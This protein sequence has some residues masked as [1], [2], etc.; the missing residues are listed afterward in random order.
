MAN[1]SCLDSEIF[2]KKLGEIKSSKK[3]KARKIKL[4]IDD[5][6]YNDA[7]KWLETRNEDSKPKD[8]TNLTSQ[9][10]AIIKEKDGNWMVAKYYP[11]T[12]KKLINNVNYTKLFAKPIRILRTKE[13]TSILTLTAQY[14]KNK[15]QSPAD[16]N[17]LC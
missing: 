14:T 17:S 6:F 16:K 15:S 1:T 13:E 8:R 10:V 11:R 4:F 7:V 3:T 5:N 2:Y 9:D 12:E